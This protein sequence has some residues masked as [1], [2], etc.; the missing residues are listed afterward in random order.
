MAYGKNRTEGEIRDTRETQRKEE[1]RNKVDKNK[2][3][4]MKHVTQ[5]V[6]GGVRMLKHGGI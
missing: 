5:D 4:E 2:T 1:F 6:G 3:E